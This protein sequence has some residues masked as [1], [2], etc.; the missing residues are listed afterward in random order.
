MHDGGCFCSVHPYRT[1]GPSA[2]TSVQKLVE[3]HVHAS[4][5]LDRGKNVV[6]PG[7]RERQESHFHLVN[8]DLAVHKL[9]YHH[10]DIFFSWQTAELTGKNVKHMARKN[11]HILRVSWSPSYR[12]TIQFCFQRRR[13]ISL[14]PVCLN[15]PC[16]R[17]CR[18]SPFLYL[19]VSGK[20]R[21]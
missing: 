13:F 3:N 4:V 2:E 10:M 17:R 7:W 1:C 18:I 12:N 9:R 8:F 16:R 6:P 11:I 14:P 5:E 19:T 15:K 21:C 20:R